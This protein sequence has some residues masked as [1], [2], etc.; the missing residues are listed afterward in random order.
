MKKFALIAALVCALAASSVAALEINIGRA[1]YTGELKIMPPGYFDFVP[2]DGFRVVG[3]NTVEDA[4]CH[5][6]EKV[7]SI[8]KIVRELVLDGVN[9]ISALRQAVRR[10]NAANDRR[11]CWFEGRLQVFSTHLARRGYKDD[12]DILRPVVILRLVTQDGRRSFY[13]GYHEGMRYD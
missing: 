9:T 3:S 5:Q 7:I 11:V 12:D 4:F 1:G 13:G 8:H 10:V 6:W 2:Y